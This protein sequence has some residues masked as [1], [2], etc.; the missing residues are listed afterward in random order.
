MMCS[1]TPYSQAVSAV[2]SCI[3]LECTF[4]NFIIY[5][6]VKLILLKNYFSMLIELPV[7]ASWNISLT[8]PFLGNFMR[9]TL[10]WLP[11]EELWIL[12]RAALKKELGIYPEQH[13]LIC[14]LFNLYSLCWA[15]G[16]IKQ[17]REIYFPLHT[18]NRKSVSIFSFKTL[19]ELFFLP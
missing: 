4:K 2:L 7:T 17:Y 5:S 3:K 1:W 15:P 19:P 8:E 13:W 9:S 11:T 18:Q 10:S 6:N 16:R 12:W 14:Y